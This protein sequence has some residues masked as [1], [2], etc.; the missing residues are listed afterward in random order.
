[1]KCFDEEVRTSGLSDTYY[2]LNAGAAHIARLGETNRFTMKAV[3]R[4]CSVER[5]V[6]DSRRN[7]AV[8]D[9]TVAVSGE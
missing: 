3:D 8:L 9:C 6:T 5:N 1:M 4:G 7:D 2:V